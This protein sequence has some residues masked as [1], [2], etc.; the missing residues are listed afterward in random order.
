[1]FPK[2]QYTELI[3]KKL[4]SFNPEGI[5]TPLEL[6]LSDL[7]NVVGVQSKIFDDFENLD[8]L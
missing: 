8:L 7:K 1:M 5:F 2:N 3:E 4:K 6:D